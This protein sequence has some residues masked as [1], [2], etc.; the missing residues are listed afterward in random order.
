[1]ECGYFSRIWGSNVHA[2]EINTDLQIVL[3]GR[4]KKTKKR[5][6]KKKK[7]KKTKKKKKKRR[8]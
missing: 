7:N 2:A 8:K 4:K 1:M 3:F 5:K 6:K